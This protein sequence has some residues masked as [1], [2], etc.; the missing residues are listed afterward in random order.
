MR[1]ALM[2]VALLGGCS[3][4]EMKPVAPEYDPRTIPRCDADDLYAVGDAVGSAAFIVLLGIVI[5]VDPAQDVSTGERVGTGVATGG[6]A[7]LFGASSVAGFRWSSEC[8]AVKKQ[9]DQRQIEQDTL[10]QETKR[11]QSTDAEVL[12]RRKPVVRGH[13]CATS[14]SAGLCAREKAD[15][16]TARDAALAAVAD[17]GTCTLVESAHCFDA[18]GRERCFPTAEQCA[19]RSERHSCQERK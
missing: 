1:A 14:A 8:D 15:C 19:A 4:I 9:W 12:K 18:T 13:F 16:E 11:D 2:F 5:F 3:F 6:L 17:L 10:V 7:L